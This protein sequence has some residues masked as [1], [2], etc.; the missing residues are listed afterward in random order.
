MPIEYAKMLLA[1]G[2]GII[3]KLFILQRN[4]DGWRYCRVMANAAAVV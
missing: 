2:L 4:I 1:Y 3:V